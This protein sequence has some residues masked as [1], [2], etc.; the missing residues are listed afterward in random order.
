M[1]LNVSGMIKST[2]I[3]NLECIQCGACVDSC[4]HKIFSYGMMKGKG[5]K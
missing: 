2:H 1:G 3:E 4:P 5:E